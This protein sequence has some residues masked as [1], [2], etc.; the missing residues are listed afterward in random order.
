MISTDTDPGIESDLIDLSTVS[1]GRLRE[2]NSSA[3]HQAMRRAL[4]KAVNLR[5]TRG[6]GG[7][8]SGGERID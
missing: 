1:F 8:E 3:L 7:N 4:T 6:S 5:A 2:L